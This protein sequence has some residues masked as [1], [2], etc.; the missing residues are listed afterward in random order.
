MNDTVVTRL[1]ALI[2]PFSV[3]DVV[4]TFEGG[5]VVTTGGPAV[6]NVMSFPFD[7]PPEFVP[8]TRK[9]YRVFG[10]SPAIAAETGV[11]EVPVTGDGTAVAVNPYATVVP[12]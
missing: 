11:T 4:L 3:A 5:M 7:V 10:V 9:W 1:L 6:V 2:F 8:T 12:Y